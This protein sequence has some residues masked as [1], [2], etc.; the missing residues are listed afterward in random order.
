M[1][2]SRIRFSMLWL[3]LISRHTGRMVT[4]VPLLRRSSA[5]CPLLSGTACK[6]AVAHGGKGF[7]LAWLAVA[8]SMIVSSATL[9]AAE[10]PALNPFG[11][12]ASEARPERDDA[13]PGCLELSDGSVHP[14][15]IYLTRDKRLKIYDDRL[16]RQ[17]EVPLQTVKRIE[18][19]VKRGWMEKEWKFKETTSDEKILTGRTYPAR[20]Y[21]HTITLRDGRTITG[22]LVAIVY[23]QPSPQQQAE[24]F[25][26]NKRNKGEPGK[27]LKSLVYVKQIKLG[28]EALEEGVK[29]QKTVR[30]H[31]AKPQAVR[32]GGERPTPRSKSP[33]SDP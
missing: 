3:T 7:G 19:N 23:V 17:R 16:Q 29:K 8:I 33:I 13:V 26:L 18:C 21:L 14:G 10:P 1:R 9:S 30:P 11:P 6:Q 24:R 31:S 5:G 27:N 20:E 2:V 15:L 4:S 28:K 22:P 12:A 25:L 32:V